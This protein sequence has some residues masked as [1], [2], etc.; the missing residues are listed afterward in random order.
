M[1]NRLSLAQPRARTAYDSVSLATTTT[2]RL[3]RRPPARRLSLNT[4]LYEKH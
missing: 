2:I 1:Y 3:Q 4:L